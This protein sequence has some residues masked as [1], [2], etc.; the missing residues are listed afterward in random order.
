ML[1]VA[2]I[3]TPS[4]TIRS[5]WRLVLF[6]LFVGLVPPP[7][8]AT[9]DRQE[10]A[11]LSDRRVRYQI[12]ARLDTGKKEIHGRERLTWRNP[13]P[14]PVP[15]LQ[16]HLYL[17]AFR[18][19]NSSFRRGS[20]GGQLRGDAMDARFPGA[21]DLLSMRTEDGVDL[22]PR[23]EF[24]HPD[25]DN[26]DDRTVWR[27]VLPQPVPAGGSI[28]LDIEFLAKLPK[29]FA[30]TGYY[31]NFFMVAQWFPKL[32]VYEP[33][34]MRRRT[35]PGWNCHQFHA[36]TEFYADFGEYDVTLDVPAGF[37]VGATGVERERQPQPDGRMRYRFVQGDVHDFAWTCSPDFIVAEERFEVPDL[38]PVRLILLLQPE[39]ADQRA[40]HFRAARIALEDYGRRIGPYP[41]ETLT[42][43]DPAHGADG[44]GGME[45]PTLIT[46]GTRR[47]VSDDDLLGPEVILIHEF[48]HQYWYGMVASN[49]FEE[50]WLDEGINSYCEATL[51]ARHYPT[52]Q[53]LWLRL[54]G[55]PFWRLP[56]RVPDWSFQRVQLFVLGPAGIQSA[57]ILT[58]GWKFPE[59]A[60]YAF[61]AYA[62]PALTLRMLEGYVGSETM[63]RILH[64]YFMRWRF[65]H[66]TSEDFF[67]VASEVA[68]EDLTWFFDQ[69]FRGTSL[70]DYAVESLDAREAVL[71][72]K[73]EAIMPQVIE[74]RFADGSVRRETWD[75]RSERHRL[76]TEGE[77]LSVV[78]DPDD[79]VRLDMNPANNSRTRLSVARANA[80]LLTRALTLMQWFL[81]GAVSLM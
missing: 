25:D 43:V 34:G 28:T 38:P 66:P 30:R 15:D 71:V 37:K 11:P 1:P 7:A 53:E 74:L 42:I 67:D 58:P 63:Q 14:H 9:T 55:R 13:A 41:Y 27:V 2:R 24:I 45:Y 46:I 76:T 70:L 68:G 77:L 33:V 20:G 40:R 49:E 18:D 73:G 19:E 57:P 78:I 44:A 59:P 62:R 75:G 61:N 16:F 36:T 60:L 80:S 72:R 3:T 31:G 50:A 10:T 56:V 6:C 48:G 65:R 23:G 69:Y 54:G 5:L 64:T 4:P 32:G 81:H 22:L 79:T 8:T 12:D 39:H 17:N 51:M 29:V 52:Q 47:N 35:T 26:A 21:I